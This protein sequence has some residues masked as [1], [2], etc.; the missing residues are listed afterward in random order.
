MGKKRRLSS[1]PHKKNENHANKEKETEKKPTTRQLRNSAKLED[2]Y[3]EEREREIVEPDISIEEE[4]DEVGEARFRFYGALKGLTDKKEDSE[5]ESSLFDEEEQDDEDMY[6]ESQ[7]IVHDKVRQVAR[8]YQ[9]KDN[10]FGFTSSNK[11]LAGFDVDSHDDPRLGGDSLIMKQSYVMKLFDRSVDLAQFD[12][13]TP[14]YPIC[15][16]WVANQPKKPWEKKKEAPPASTWAIKE[17]TEDEDPEAP[18]SKKEEKEDKEKEK[19]VDD[20][21]I[22]PSQIELKV[23]AK[24]PPPS[25][26]VDVKAPNIRIPQALAKFIDKNNQLLPDEAKPVEELPSQ[27]ELLGGHLSRWSQ[28]KTSWIHASQKNEERYL[29]SRQLLQMMYNRSQKQPAQ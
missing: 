25:Y 24:L 15:R 19:E 5:S 10:S 13:A 1:T 14:L 20:S 16:S 26:F 21:E 11:F 3:F 6:S 12:D 29:K 23:I 2:S 18:V 27:E 17:E 4:K 9:D 7:F 28:V 8:R 22:E